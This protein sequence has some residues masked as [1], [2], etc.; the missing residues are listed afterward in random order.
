MQKSPS[1]L[2]EIRYRRFTIVVEWSSDLQ[3]CRQ[4]GSCAISILDTSCKIT[5]LNFN[6]YI[7]YPLPHLATLYS[8]DINTYSHL[9]SDEQKDPYHAHTQ[10][11][12]T[13]SQEE[14]LFWFC[15]ITASR[16]N[17]SFLIRISIRYSCRDRR[18]SRRRLIRL[19]CISCSVVVIL[20]PPI[21]IV[22]S[23]QQ[24]GTDWLFFRLEINFHLNWSKILS[25]CSY[26]DSVP[27]PCLN[28]DWLCM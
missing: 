6:Q 24:E 26:V 25:T 23:R 7:R 28:S 5:S 21:L 17:S 18:C 12:H 2:V 13:L 1:P 15:L 10:H 8:L 22:L 9:P 27:L 19:C 11:T 20:S 16:S 3:L 14:V 4:V